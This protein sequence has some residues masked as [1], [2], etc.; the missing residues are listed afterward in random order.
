MEKKISTLIFDFGNVII[1]I[2]MSSTID[3]ITKLTEVDFEAIFRQ[4]E[5]V[6]IQ[7]EKGLISTEAFI[8][9]IIRL[10]KK[11]IHAN[12]IVAIWNSI[13]LDIPPIRLKIL[14]DLSQRYQLYLLSNTN[15]L[16]IQWAHRYMKR[17]YNVDNFETKYFNQVFYSHQLKARKPDQEI[18][19]MV[20]DRIGV[21][22]EEILFIDDLKEN[23]TAAQDFGWNSVLHPAQGDL[24]I[25]LAGL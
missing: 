5:S 16:H 17:K 14:E 9:H 4:D 12:E 2:D 13:L 25:T 6:F 21:D 15:T 24:K 18:Y 22:K 10:S 3:A 8:N 19:K 23:V 7:Y 1:D 11:P 20:N